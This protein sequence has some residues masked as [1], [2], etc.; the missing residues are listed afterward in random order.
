MTDEAADTPTRLIEAAVAMIDEGGE[1][2]IRLRDIAS[3]AGVTLPSIYH[4][5]GSRDGLIEE[6]QAARYLRSQIGITQEFADSIFTCRSRRSFTAIVRRFLTAALD[7]R[8][9]AL[10]SVRI[11]VLGSAQARPAL[12]VRLASEQRAANEA[13]AV[14]LRYAQRRG[15][16]R[17]DVDAVTVAAW[18]I[19]TVTGRLFVETDPSFDDLTGWDTVTIEAVLAV[20]GPRDVLGDSAVAEPSV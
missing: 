8:R 10:R 20:L 14:P 12:G 18:V 9:T 5:F 4:F 17:P 6:A 19:T 13:L 7:S 2:S 11:E 16:M 15:W 3:T 1:G